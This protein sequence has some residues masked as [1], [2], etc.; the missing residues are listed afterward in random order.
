MQFHKPALLV[1]GDWTTYGEGQSA[2][3]FRSLEYREE[4]EH[5]RKYRVAMLRDIHE[6]ESR[7]YEGDLVVLDADGGFIRVLGQDSDALA[8]H[9]EFKILSRSSE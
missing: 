6:R 8:L 3:S 7:L 2:L 5:I 9:A 4:V 1:A